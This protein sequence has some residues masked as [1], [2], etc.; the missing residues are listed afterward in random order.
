MSEDQERVARELAEELR[1]LRVE[2][3]LINTLLTVSSIGYRRL[4]VTEDTREDRDLEQTRLAIETMRT[5]TP[6]LERFVPGELVR[7]F[8]QSVANLQLAYA[9]AASGARPAEVPGEAAEPGGAAAPQAAEPA[10]AAGTDAPDE[11]PPSAG[12]P[13]AA[14][15]PEVAPEELQ[16][17]GEAPPPAP[18]AGTSSP[19]DGPEQAAEDTPAA[20]DERRPE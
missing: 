9:S 3:V 12:S 7:D 6:V 14:P 2:D 18:A 8:N 15:E 20:G 13:S 10:E 5:L 4:G 17:E 11:E 19:G 1:K 16:G